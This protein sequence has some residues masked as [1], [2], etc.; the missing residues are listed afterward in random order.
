MIYPYSGILFGHKKESS[1]DKATMRMNLENIMLN[2]RSQ[3]QKT[4]YCMI[5]FIWNIGKS[6]ETES[7]L[8]VA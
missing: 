8:V 2:E 1:T 7:R 3:S 6:T 4:T 5:P